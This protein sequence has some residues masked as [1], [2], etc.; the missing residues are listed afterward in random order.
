MRQIRDLIMAEI[1]LVQPEAA[2]MPLIKQW[3]KPM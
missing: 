1:D 2:R 3:C